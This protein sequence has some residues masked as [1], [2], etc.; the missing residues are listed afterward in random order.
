MLSN[1]MNDLQSNKEIIAIFLDFKRAFETVDRSLLLQKLSV[2]GFDDAAVK[3]FL[4]Y[5]SERTQRVKIDETYSEARDVNIGLPQGSILSP[6]LIIIYI[7]DLKFVLKNCTTNI[8]A[9]DT[10][11]SVGDK[12][13]SVAY[14]KMSEDLE[15]L[16][17]WLRFDKLALTIEKTSML[18]FNNKQSQPIKQEKLGLLRRISSSLTNESKLIFYKSLVEPHFDY[19]ASILFLLSDK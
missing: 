14:A 17:D 5:L 13:G 10:M 15:R 2:Y 19:C 1:W 16:Q 9:D 3:W 18:H 6:L 12:D 11:A 4:S 8:F 7:N